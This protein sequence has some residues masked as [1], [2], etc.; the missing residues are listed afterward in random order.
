M[1]QSSKPYQLEKSVWTDDDLENMGW[2]DCKLFGISFG[3]NFQ[4][5]LDIDYIFKLVKTGKT[6]KFWVSPCTLVFENV[7]DLEFQMDGISNGIE[8]DDITRDNSQ[9][10][11]NAD[12]IKRDTE[13]D[14]TIEAQQGS[15]CFKSVGLKQYVRKVPKLIPGQYLELSTKRWYLI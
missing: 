2:H 14:W 15:I 13:F 6:F 9:N 3:D 11:R 12:F 7:Y 10:P 1:T 8:I 4:M 5:L